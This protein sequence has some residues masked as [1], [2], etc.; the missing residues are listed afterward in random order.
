MEGLVCVIIA[1]RGFGAH[2]NSY[3]FT[4]G[5]LSTRVPGFPGN[6]RNPGN[7][8]GRLAHYGRLTC[9]GRLPTMGDWPARGEKPCGEAQREEV[10]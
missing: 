10:A 4:R 3:G 2:Q 8:E 1:T 5:D 7:N 6:P 9:E